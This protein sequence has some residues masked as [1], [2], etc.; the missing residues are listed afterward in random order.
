MSPI[1]GLE[2]GLHDTSWT[3]MD[4]PLTLCF[5]L[6]IVQ[7]SMKVSSLEI[8]CS[9]RYAIEALVELLDLGWVITMD[10]WDHW[11]HCTSSPPVDSWTH[12]S[13]TT[14]MPHELNAYGEYLVDVGTATRQ[15]PLLTHLDIFRCVQAASPPLFPT[16]SQTTDQPLEFAELGKRL[17]SNTP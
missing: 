2:Q 4:L 9:M 1:E 5:T 8:C 13:H 16:S 15:D 12:V 14:S 3:F 17:A 6:W 10:H 11:D 7:V